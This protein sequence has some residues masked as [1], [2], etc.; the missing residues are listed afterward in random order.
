MYKVFLLILIL[1]HPLVSRSV[2][3]DAGQMTLDEMISQ[4]S[5][6]IVGKVIQ[7]H[8]IPYSEQYT[9]RIAEV[10][11]VQHLKGDESAQTV[12]YQVSR[13]RACDITSAIIGQT[14]IFLL[15][16]DTKFRDYP[17]AHVLP[18]LRAITKNSDLLK[19]VHQGRGRLEAKYINDDYYV[20]GIRK[21]GEV[22]F[23]RILKMIDYPDPEY[24]YVG[25]IK[26]N[27]L[28]QYLNTASQK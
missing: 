22:L 15:S 3:A 20:L 27:D 21:G 18:Y 4:S 28:L 16:P 7:V 12:Y 24:S 13:S 9:I 11:V 14:D 23:P 10:Q 2:S 5:H 1:L 26:L 25:M 8:S 6:I 19:I 17:D